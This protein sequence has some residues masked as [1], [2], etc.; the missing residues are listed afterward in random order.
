MSDDIAKLKP[1][2]FCGG[3]A[4]LATCRVAEDEVAT[5]AVCTSC[6]AT[7]SETSDAY[8]DVATA[9]AIWNTRA[10]DDAKDKRIAE[11][12]AALEP[13]AAF[14]EKRHARYVRRGGS[15]AGFPDSHPS[16]DIDA[17][18]RELP[19]GVW[20]AAARLVRPSPEAE[21]NE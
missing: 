7:S 20:R 19:L 18:K 4:K 3:K 6:G 11:L 12:E 14:Y 1:C 5:W 9:A 21:A 15:F 2:P 13:F 10:L 8:R 16:F 17:D